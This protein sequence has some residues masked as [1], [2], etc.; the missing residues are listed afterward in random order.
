AFV[1]E[2]AG[3]RDQARTLVLDSDSAAKVTYTLVRGAGSR[4][5]DA[6]L[7][8]AG[9]SNDRLDKTV[10]HLVAGSGAD[11]T[12]QLGGFAVRYILVKDGAPR[13]MGRVL[14]ATP[15]LTRLSQQDGSALWRVNRQVARATVVTGS[16]AP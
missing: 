15:G 9:G 10:A 7:T 14:D 3:T 13:Q 6:E 5:G 12:D 8:E 1:A 11:Q 2:E 16:G 4:L